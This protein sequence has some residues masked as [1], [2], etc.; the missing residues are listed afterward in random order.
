MHVRHFPLSFHKRAEPAAWAVQAAQEQGKGWEMGEVVFKNYRAL[1]DPELMRYA[2]G[3]GLDMPKFKAA[4]GGA[5]VKKQVQDDVAAARA[6]G[7]V[8]GTPTILVNGAKY[9]GQRTVQGFQTVIDSELE[10]ADVL[11]KRGIPPDKLYEQL[12]KAPP[13]PAP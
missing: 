13:E 10:R 7:A 12:C 2:K 4:Y 3:I 1:D 6:S 5:T 8:R 9:K 11:L